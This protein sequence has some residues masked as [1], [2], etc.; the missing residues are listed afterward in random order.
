[1]NNDENGVPVKKDIY[2][3]PKRSLDS[4][5]ELDEL[6]DQLNIVKDKKGLNMDF[7]TTVSDLKTGGKHF[8]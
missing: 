8:H 2:L 4:M 5:R 3:T 6:E 1:M 7:K